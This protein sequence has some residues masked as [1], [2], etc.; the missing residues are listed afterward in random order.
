MCMRMRCAWA[1]GA[2]ACACAC[3][4]ASQVGLQALWLICEKN[5]NLKSLTLRDNGVGGV[6]VDS[7][8]LA[9]MLVTSTTL[10]SL[11]LSS[12]VLGSLGNYIKVYM[13]T[14]IHIYICMACMQRTCMRA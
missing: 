8:G 10:E 7:Y 13:L 14:Y 4:Y 5:D 11:D 3:A 2:C 12:N 9:K 6:H 1:W